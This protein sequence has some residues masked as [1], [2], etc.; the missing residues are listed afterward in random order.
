LT[1]PLARDAEQRPFT[2]VEPSKFIDQPGYNAATADAAGDVYATDGL[3]GFYKY[4]QDGSVVGSWPNALS[5]TVG[6]TVDSVG[7]I[8]VANFDHATVHKF[9]S[10]GKP[11]TQWSVGGGSPGPHGLAHDAQDNIYVALDRFHDQYV[12]KYSQDGTLLATWATTGEGDGQINADGATEIAVD[13]AGNSYVVD[14]F[15]NR[16]VSFGPDGKFRYN[17]TGHGD[18][19]LI[20]PGTV[21]TDS[22]GNVYVDSGLTLWKFDRMGSFIGEWFTPMLGPIVVDAQDRVFQVDAEIRLLS[23]PTP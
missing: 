19:K 1:R 10:T 11:L 12:E 8:Y 6:T 4:R 17:L 18:R 23:F 14:G 20:H 16:V 9:D 3:S 5:Y 7:N 15:N 2:T 21:A 13:G 22:Q